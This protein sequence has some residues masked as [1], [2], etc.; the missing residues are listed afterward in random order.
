MKSGLEFGGMRVLS[1]G[2]VNADICN[3]APTLLLATDTGG[4]LLGTSTPSRGWIFR[5]GLMKVSDEI[6]V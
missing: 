5:M 4:V 2:G 1:N 3:R 6:W